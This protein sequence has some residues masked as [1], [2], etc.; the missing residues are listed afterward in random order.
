M[1]SLSSL[2]AS[3]R[4]DRHA[5]ALWL[6]LGVSPQ[7]LSALTKHF[8]DLCEVFRASP[9]DLAPFKFTAQRCTQRN[10]INW[11]HIDAHIRWA[12][13][14]QQFIIPFDS[15]LYP[16][17]LKHITSPPA[18]LMVKGD[19]RLL[20]ERQIAMVGSR[21][22]THNGLAIAKQIA[23]DLAANNVVVTSGL[24][25]G[26]D[27]AS[28]QG[29]LSSGG[30]TIAV[31]ATG[32][33][34]IYPKRHTAL[35]NDILNAGVLVSEVALDTKP[36]RQNFPRRNRI[37]S[38]LSLGTLVVEAAKKSG[39]LI[40]AQFALDQSRDVFAVPSS[41]YNQQSEGCHSLLQQGAALVTNAKDILDE[42]DLCWYTHRSSVQTT[43]S[44]SHLRKTLDKNQ[45]MLIKCLDFDPA[46][47][48]EIVIR[49]QLSAS[50]VSRLLV[51][52][53]LQ[54]VITHTANGYQL[55]TLKDTQH[56]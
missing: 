2:S 13:H 5:L 45:R 54:S 20:S 3:D 32:V 21:V 48:D 22:A 27:G 25:L 18:F 4:I 24:A 34:E 38:G 17:L 31:L 23:A 9:K 16:H 36:L 33:E 43:L 49:S 14:P 19:P 26:I 29:A 47:I 1:T 39:S 52:L 56:E 35:A 41:I 37:I 40:T 55:S 46:S 15:H 42:I 12:E 28:H 8:G 53:E 11:A 51:E 7:R 30:K 50:T 10:A 6:Y 44:N